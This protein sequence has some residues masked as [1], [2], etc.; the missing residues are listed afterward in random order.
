MG[1]AYS[2]LPDSPGTLK[3][4][5]ADTQGR[6]LGYLKKNIS[7]DMDLGDTNDFEL[8][9]NTDAWDEALYSWGHRI[10]IPGTEYGGLL[11]ERKTSASDGTGRWIGYTWRGLLN[12]K[13][14]QPPAGQTHLTVSGEMNQIIREVI[15]GRFGSL[16]TGSAEDSGIYVDSY[17]FEPYCTLLDGLTR[18]LSAQN[19]R[20]SIYYEQGEPAGPGGQICV[21]AVPAAD[22][23]DELEYS[24]DG[25][26]SFA[27]QD[28]RRG[29]NH[30]ICVGK[31]NDDERAVLHLYVQ[32]DGT[33]G[34]A[35][36]YYG[37]D[38]R[39][40]VYHASSSDPDQLRE[41][42]TE[43]LLKLMNWKQMEVTVND[44]DIAIGDIV[45]GRDRITGMTL[46]KP[47][48][49]KVLR[50]DSGIMSV[51]YKLKGEE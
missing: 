37:L 42:G 22:W 23:S 51:E 20:L 50:F 6:E 25:K 34:D 10:F 33:I 31:K 9:V 17:Q 5:V 49:N 24:Q 38:E 11:E 46:Q 45:G 8:E 14:V 44:I 4:I 1:V 26:M 12:Q 28:Y 29:I 15:G 13:I 19:A 2:H 7:I 40:A 16:F 18:L 48:V 41:N 39:E 21:C 35:R 3:F 32:K 36:H 30:L 47:V 43:R 27:T